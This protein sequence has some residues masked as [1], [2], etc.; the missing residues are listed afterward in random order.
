M[1]L[2][3]WTILVIGA[4]FAAAP[5]T[6]QI[7]DPNYPVCIEI[8]S[9]RGGSYIDC[10]YTSI[11]QCNATA[12]GRGARCLIIHILI[13]RHR[14]GP[15]GTEARSPFDRSGAIGWVSALRGAAYSPA[16]LKRGRLPPSSAR[17]LV[18]SRG[19]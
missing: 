9:P 4:T 11:P 7:Y 14:S 18:S 6:A 19:M 16:I 17:S 10:S 12:S 3:I 5:A 15:C 2:L 1:R 13:L 8:F